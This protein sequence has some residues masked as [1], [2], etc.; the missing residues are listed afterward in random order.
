MDP[1]KMLA[2][3]YT[4]KTVGTFCFILIAFCAVLLLPGLGSITMQRE[5]ELRVVLTARH[6]AEGGGWLLPEFLGD[7]RFRKPPLMYWIVASTFKLAGT[8]TSAFIARL[9]GVIAGALLVLSLFLAGARL[10]GRRRA[11]LASVI[12]MTSFIF[13]RQARLMEIDITLALCVTLSTIS[14]YLALTRRAE[15]LRWWTLAGIA[16]GLGFL[17]KGPAALALPP[18]AWLAFAAMNPRRLRA[19]MDLRVLPGLL[20]CILIGAPWYIAIR[21]LAEKQIATELTATF[22]ESHHPG[23]IYYYLYTLL[24]AMLPWSI[25]LPFA[26]W[27]IARH[28]RHHSGLRFLLTWFAT[29]FAALSVVDSKQIHYC[30][31][32]LPPSA[33]VLGWYAARFLAVRTPAV[34]ACALRYGAASLVLAMAAGS[35]IYAWSWHPQRDP[36]YL[37]QD[38]ARKARPHVAAAHELFITGPD[39]AAL[40]FYVAR[41]PRYPADL[42][43]AWKDARTGDV[44]LVSGNHR[45]PIDHALLPAP[46]ALEMK[47]QKAEFILLSKTAGPAS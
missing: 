17:A 28:G 14:G 43:S 12:G 32:L 19:F 3:I 46:P 26:L 42:A 25:L 18:L 1:A 22:A 35:A 13:M 31:L 34:R 7:F 23:P 4:R 41:K 40:E 37:I 30:T 36:D 21:K 16:G 47:N 44:V 10:V 9:P 15:A 8:A 33:L 39:T 29:S 45:R 27:A 38:F 5:Q 11:F 24:H 20:A 6:M 2:P